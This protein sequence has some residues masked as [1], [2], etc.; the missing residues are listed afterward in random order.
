MAAR[1]VGGPV[2]FPPAEDSISL[3]ISLTIINLLFAAGFIWLAIDYARMLF[4]R[5]K[6]VS[7][8]LAVWIL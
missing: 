4:L 6:M 7:R 8:Q 1:G 5:R 2:E 3:K